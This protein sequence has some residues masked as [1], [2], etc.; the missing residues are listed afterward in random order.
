MKTKESFIM[1]VAPFLV[2]ISIAMIIGIP[3]YFF[4]NYGINDLFAT[5]YFMPEWIIRW[6]GA[7]NVIVF[8]PIFIIGFRTI[9]RKGAVGQA[10]KLRTW[11]AYKYV[12]N[13]MYAG[14]SFTIFG[15]GCF[16]GISSIVVSGL[17]WLIICFFQAKHEERELF[18]KYG[19]EYIVYKK[20]TPLFVPDF[21]VVF[22]IRLKKFKPQETKN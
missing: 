11:S 18:E 8:L 7:A 2:L 1:K 17:I 4:N 14:I 6:V 21:K 13:P 16:L 22:H 5:L 15:I 9:G 3:Y 12:R 20:R 10:S 19:D